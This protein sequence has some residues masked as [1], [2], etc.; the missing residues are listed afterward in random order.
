MRDEDRG[1]LADLRRRQ[2]GALPRPCAALC[3]RCGST[4]AR[5]PLLRTT[6]SS[7]S[8]W[9]LT[10]ASPRPHDGV[11]DQ[12]VG[13]AGHR[14]DGEGHAGRD[15]WTIRWIRT[16]IA[17]AS[18]EHSL[19]AP[20]LERLRRAPRG[21]ARAIAASATPARGDVEERLVDAGER[22]AVAVFAD[23]RR[24]HG[25]AASAGCVVEPGMAREP[26]QLAVGRRR[27]A[28]PRRR[29]RG[30]RPASAARSCRPWR[31]SAPHR[32]RELGERHE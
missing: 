2:R 17:I 27:R 12:L 8:T 22:L 4:A 20:V 18:V 24:A 1:Q 11:D 26:R 29:A 30:S 19:R 14:V 6:N 23:A 9:P 21:A 32:R 15:G 13:R 28:R 10:S 31:R 7:G 3:R 5:R 25:E 16:P